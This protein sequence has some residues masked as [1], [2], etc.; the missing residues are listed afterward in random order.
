MKR[1]ARL[2]SSKPGTFLARAPSRALIGRIMSMNQAVS[3]TPR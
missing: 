2:G 3:E 1:T